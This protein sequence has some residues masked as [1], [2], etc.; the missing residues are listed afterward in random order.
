VLKEFSGPP[1]PGSL[2]GRLRKADS[3]DAAEA[4]PEDSLVY[5]GITSKSHRHRNDGRSNVPET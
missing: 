5:R 3:S 1:P 2:E 4:I